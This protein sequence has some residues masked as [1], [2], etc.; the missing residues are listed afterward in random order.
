MIEV[1]MME[2]GISDRDFSIVPFPINYPEY[3][4]H[5]VPLNATFFVTIYDQWGEHKLKTLKALGLSTNVMWRRKM[6]ERFTTGN[7]VRNYIREGKSWKKLVPDGVY[8]YIIE[9]NLI[10]QIK[11]S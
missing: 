4:K 2:A 7:E 1:A 6:S 9:N 3:I 10:E 5:Y 8:K 11:T